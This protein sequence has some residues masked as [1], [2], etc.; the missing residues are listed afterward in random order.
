[1]SSDL[2]ILGFVEDLLLFVLGAVVV[3]MYSYG[4]VWA[5]RILKALMTPLYRERARWVG[6]VAIFFGI[7]V[8]S[9]LLIR[10]FAESNFYLSFLE[11]FITNAAGMVT[12]AWIDTTIKMA[13]RSDPLNR[14]TIKWKQL[15]YV[16]WAFTFITSA[17]SLV[18]VAYLRLN[19]FSSSGASGDFVSGAFGW[20]LFGFIALVLSYRRSRDPILKEHLKWFGLFLFVLFIVNTVLSHNIYGFIIADEALLALDAYFLYRGVKSLAPLSKVPLERAVSST[21]S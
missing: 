16:I 19:F 6:V 8:A 9:N 15:R 17:G 12:L 13:R 4:A 1:M 11:Y 18:S 7:L 14:N 10:A 20:V 5:F 2:S 3:A 21:S